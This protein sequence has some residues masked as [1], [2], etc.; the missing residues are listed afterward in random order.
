MAAAA[1][2]AGEA[3]A[4]GSAQR[5]FVAYA[6]YAAAEECF[7]AEITRLIDDGATRLCDLGGGFHPVLRPRRIA[8]NELDYVVF[9]A[10]AAQLERT[11][12]IY[13]RFLGDVLDAQA[14]AELI[15]ERGPFDAVVSHFVAEHIRD[16]R[17]FH[18]RVFEL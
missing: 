17:V 4:G 5:G 13:T 6:H 18:E 7:R 1:A 10:S 2:N 16:G 11:P 9:D 14:V 12:E 8:N 3:T 15:R